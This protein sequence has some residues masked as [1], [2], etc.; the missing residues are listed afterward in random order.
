MMFNLRLRPSDAGVIVNHRCQ[1]TV[2]VGVIYNRDTNQLPDVVH[3][4]G[5]FISVSLRN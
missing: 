5:K 3:T 1:Y 2:T 4:D